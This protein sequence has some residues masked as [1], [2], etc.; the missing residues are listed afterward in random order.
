[1][2][3][4]P[5]GRA[6]EGWDRKKADALY[7]WPCFSRRPRCPPPPWLGCGL[8]RGTC[9]GLPPSP[10]VGFSLE[11]LYFSL[12]VGGDF[13]SLAAGAPAV[14]M[15]LLPKLLLESA[16][17][18]SWKGSWTVGCGSLCLNLSRVG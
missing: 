17:F 3:D 4:P 1:M 15:E 14:P 8:F 6:G 18:C 7:K 9:G 10:P 2:A 11:V 5:K 13:V 12:G 16:Q